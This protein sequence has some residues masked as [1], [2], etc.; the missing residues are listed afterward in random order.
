MKG[1]ACLLSLACGVAAGQTNPFSERLYPIFQTAGCP[2]C[3]NSN[4]VASATRLHFP[5]ASA[6][7]DQMEAFGRSLVRLVDREHPEESLL[8]KKPT[9]RVAHTGGER[10]KP[11]SPEEATLVSWIRFLA[12]MPANEVT[13]ALRYD[14]AGRT[15]ERRKG[16][17]LRR[18]T[19]SQYN[20]TVRDLLG[21]QTEPASEFPPEDFVSGF[22]DQYDSQNLSPILEEAYSDIAEKL[23]QNAFRNGD[24]HHLIPCTAGPSCRGQFVREFGQKAFRRPLDEDEKRRYL[25]LFNREKTF[26]AGAQLVVE[27]MLQSP[28]FVF[29][30]DETSNPA[31]KGFATASRLSYALWDSMPDSELLASAAR[32][33]LSSQEQIENTARRML[34]DPRA[35]Q[36]VN[37]YISEWLRFDR[38]LNSAR[39]R[40]R[41]PKFSRETAVAMTEEARLFISDLIWNDHNFM[42]AFSA[43]YGFVNADLA[44]IYGVPAPTQDFS[45]VAFPEQSERAGLLGQALFLALSAKPDDTSLTGRGLFVREQFLCQHVPPPPV[46]VNTNLAPSTEAHPQTNRA[47]MSEHATNQFCATCH[48]LI[49]PI[50]VGFEK[51]DAVGARRDRYK[52]TFYG[53]HGEGRRPPKSVELDMDTK[54]WVAGIPDSNFSS[55]RDLG[56]I[57][58]RTRQCQ[59]C[60]VKQYFRYVT[61]RVET[62]ADIPLIQKVVEDFRKSNFRFQELIISLIRNREGLLDERNMYVA[63]NHKAF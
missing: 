47:R 34:R 2:N 36:A 6:S 40:R 16:A 54:G 21:D 22:K 18:L 60:M 48:N 15:S 27:A 29:R 35:Q 63:N 28:N 50:G 41:Y 55:P 7:V 58:A 9:M 61:G 30:L 3:H 11:G 53:G 13:E 44:A 10:I 12:A 19:N 24:T 39:D 23:A 38:V 4:G 8:L 42:D 52:L 59:E 57:L 5:D 26:M 25:S 51:F 37:E 49:D 31:W 43:S 1:I 17:V 56:A 45:R 14:E 46:G 20:N 62:P 32:G 33:E